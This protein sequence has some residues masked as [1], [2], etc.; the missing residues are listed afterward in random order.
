MGSESL[1]QVFSSMAKPGSVWLTSG[2]KGGGKSHTAIAVAEQFVKGKY[3]SVGKVVVITNIIFFHKVKGK[4][5]EET[6]PDVYHIT[7][8]KELFPIIVD[9]IEKYGRNVLVMLILDEAQG[10]IG[11]DSNKTNASIMMKDFLGTIR[12]FRLMVWFLT[13]A[14]TAIGPAFRNYLNDPKYPG[15]LTA[16]WKKDLALNRKYI[17]A[18]NLSIDPKELMMVRNFDMDEPILF[19]VPVT[20]WTKTRETLNEGEYCYDHE[21]SASFYVGDG[22]DWPD[23]N[24]TIGG[25]SSLN[26][27]STIK[28]YFQAKPETPVAVVS[29][30]LTKEMKIDLCSRAV[31]V[32]GIDL[33]TSC[34]IVNTPY[35]TM[36]NWLK[37]EGRKL[38]RNSRNPDKKRVR[39]F[40]VTPC[41]MRGCRCIYLG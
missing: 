39:N 25:V 4:I 26:A 14:A 33:K 20:E 3:P 37:K 21:A 15:N 11:G 34:K 38:V 32:C 40:F 5:L 1:D 12:K 8:M 18:H 19:R 16:K 29:T 2:F 30:E 41:I 31:E 13:P 36:R 6:P 23:F 24:R 9:S 28:Q 7:T 17:Q 10:F 27:L 22:F 35:S